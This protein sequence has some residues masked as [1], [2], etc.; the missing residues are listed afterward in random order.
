MTEKLEVGDRVYY[1]VYPSGMPDTRTAGTV[2]EAV[3]DGYRVE[4]DD[5]DYKLGFHATA[6]YAAGDLA[7]VS[8]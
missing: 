2:V 3:L 6:C 8:Q 7:R 5:V 4:W 1:R